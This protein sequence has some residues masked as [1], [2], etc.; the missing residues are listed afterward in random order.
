[1]FMKPFGTLFFVL[2]CVW[3]GSVFITSDSNLRIERTCVPVSWI[4]KLSAS[5]MSLASPDLEEATNQFFLSGKNNCQYVVWRQFFSEEYTARE[6][7]IKELQQ[8]IAE[9]EAELARQAKA[10]PGVQP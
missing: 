10:A 9:K 3:M 2:F 6:Q 5:V 8:Q 1:M 4:G 7:R